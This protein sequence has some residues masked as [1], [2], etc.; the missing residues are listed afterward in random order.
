MMSF[1][2]T[3]ENLENK[4][5]AKNF[6]FSPNFYFEC[7]KMYFFQGHSNKGGGE[8]KGNEKFSKNLKWPKV[9]NAFLPFPIFYNK[10]FKIFTKK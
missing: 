8:F 6:D 3:Q 7:E 9:G 10:K 2:I 5:I 1:S 4:K